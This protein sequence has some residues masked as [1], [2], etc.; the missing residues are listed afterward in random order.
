MFTLIQS[1][2]EDFRIKF[3]I[4][5]KG[6]ERLLGILNGYRKSKIETEEEHEALVNICDTIAALLLG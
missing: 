5:L 6:M 1:C 3:A 4:T 2:S